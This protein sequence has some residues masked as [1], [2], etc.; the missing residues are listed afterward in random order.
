[1][2]IPA[3]AEQSDQ[4]IDRLSSHLTRV[5]SHERLFVS[6]DGPKAAINSFHV[7]LSIEATISFIKSG[8]LMLFDN[9]SHRSAFGSNGTKYG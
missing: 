2:R 6:E 9:V 7:N 4:V 5:R 8:H 3:L 1:M